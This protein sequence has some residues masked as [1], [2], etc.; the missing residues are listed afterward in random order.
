[1]ETQQ[2]GIKWSAIVRAAVLM[3]II[4]LVI[5]ILIPTLYA[6]YVGFSTR[7]DMAQVNAAVQSLG[8]SIVYQVIVY[9]VFAAVALWR[10]YVLVKKVASQ[11]LLHV[12]IAVLVAVLLVFAYYMAMS[13]GN[14]AAI[15][16]QVLIIALMLAGGAF[17]GTLLKPS[18]S[19]QA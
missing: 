12:G 11:H 13:Q 5:S 4:P 17:L 10:S 6:T 8:S 7:G 9:A 1:M 16:V 15:F 18:Q 3:F 14:L 2:S 19:A